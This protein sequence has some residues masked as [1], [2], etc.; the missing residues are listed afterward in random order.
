MSAV[1]IYLCKPGQEL[2]QGK[3]EVSD[4][5]ESKADA[6]RDALQRC[7]RDRSL[8]KVAYYQVNENGDFKV[9]YTYNNPNIGNEEEEKPK[10]V[11]KKPAKK[12]GLLTRLIDSIG[13]GGNKNKKKSAAKKK[14]GKKK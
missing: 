12:K 8:A 7:A 11:K 5:I 14:S 9:I 3:V 1:E 13:G 4:S 6:Q 10:K 2:K